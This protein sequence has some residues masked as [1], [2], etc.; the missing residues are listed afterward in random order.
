MAQIEDL[1]QNIN[2][3]NLVTLVYIDTEAILKAQVILLLVD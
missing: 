3:M 1:T 2:S